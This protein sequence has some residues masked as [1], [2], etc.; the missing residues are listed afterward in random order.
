MKLKLSYNQQSVGQSV[1]VSGSHLEPKT[2]VLF[3]VWQ[4][5]VSCCGAPSLTRGWVCNLLVQLL[6]GLARAITLGSKS[7]GTQT[8]F[9]C[10][11]WDSPNLEGQIPVFISPQEQGGPVSNVARINGHVTI[12]TTV[13]GIQMNSNF[14]GCNADERGKS[15]PTSNLLKL[16]EMWKLINWPNALRA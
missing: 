11:I 7:R 1:L 9:Y 16:W 5:R 15:R 3:S 12:S 10:L 13:Y 8:I 14:P 6:F 4:L 2:R